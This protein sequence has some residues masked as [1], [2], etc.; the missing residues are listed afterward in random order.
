MGERWEKIDGYNGRYSVSDQGRI[1]NDR[2][3]RILTVN[4]GCRLPSVG[5]SVDGEQ[6]W[7]PVCLLVARA[8][9]DNPDGQYHVQ[10]IDGDRKN[11]K[12]DNLEW[13]YAAAY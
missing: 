7:V 6:R 13:V 5:L 2:T 9:V 4:Y 11:H 10:F 3:G 8:F 12:A 1:R